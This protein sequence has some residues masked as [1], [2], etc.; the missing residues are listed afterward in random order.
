MPLADAL[1]KTS[2]Y[3]QSNRKPCGVKLVLGKLDKKDHAT[4]VAVMAD[5]SVDSAH[6]YRALTVEGHSVSAQTIRRHRRKECSC[7]SV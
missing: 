6:I 3:P 5:E 2:Q 1:S 4:L 7:G